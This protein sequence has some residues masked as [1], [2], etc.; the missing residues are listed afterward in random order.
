MSSVFMVTLRCM[1]GCH[2]KLR[3]GRYEPGGTHLPYKYCPICGE[4]GVLAECD[5]EA[6]WWSAICEAAELPQ[7]V[8]EP[9]YELWRQ[10]T[11]STRFMDYVNKFKNQSSSLYEEIMQHA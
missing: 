10:D 6:D 2:E 11:T 3:I 5:S 4:E 8:L 9:I 7:V 1:K